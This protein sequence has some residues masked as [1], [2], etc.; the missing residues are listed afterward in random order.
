MIAARRGAAVALALCAVSA[1]KGAD[2]RLSAVLASPTAAAREARLARALAAPDTGTDRNA[3]LAPATPLARWVLPASLKEISGLALTSDGRLLTHGDEL[4]VIWE[5][6]YRR[7]VLVKRFVLGNGEVKGDFEAITVANGHVFLLASNGKLYEFPEGADGAHVPYHLYDTGL[8]KEC[9]F[10]GIAFDPASNALLLACKHVH[11]KGLR[12]E[13]VIYRWSLADSGAHL[14]QLTVPMASVI[15]A[16]P[17]K[18]VRPSDI[19]IDP[20][21]GNY[22]LLS[23]E[24][25]AIISITPAGAVVF[26]RTLP[27]GHHQPEGLAITKD[28]ILIISDEARQ[29]P[30]SI[31]LYRWP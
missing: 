6:D 14:T 23:S 25:Q 22:V 17:W 5:V 20:F 31:T 21:T 9:E 29:A 4:G 27:P 12:D 18:T 13:L 16:N 26:V 15:G 30:P 24:Q 2:D 8:K 19:T 3:T 28:S 11:D 7:G 10:E 1:C